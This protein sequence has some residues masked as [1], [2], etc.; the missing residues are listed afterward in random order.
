MLCFSPEP[1]SLKQ[2]EYAIQ[3][4]LDEGDLE[5]LRDRFGRSQNLGKMIS[6]SEK[7]D[8]VYML[9][10][11]YEGYIEYGLYNEIKLLIASE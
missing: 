8:P 1:V 4:C 7:L 9:R 5:S 11:C 10:M 6:F 3:D 2:N